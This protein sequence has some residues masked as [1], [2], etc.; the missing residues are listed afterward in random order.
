MD[1][2]VC[3]DT[4]G[5]YEKVLTGCGHPAYESTISEGKTYDPVDLGNIARNVGKTSRA[6][7]GACHFFGGGAAGVKHGDLDTSLLAPSKDLDVHM[8]MQGLNY[9]CTSCHVTFSHYIT[10]RHY[11]EPA[12]KNR[13]MALPKDDGN[14]LSCESCHGPSPHRSDDKLNHHTDIVAC[15]SCHIPAFARV[16]PT[17][18]SWD[19]SVAGRFDEKGRPFKKK[20]PPDIG[21]NY[22]TRK[23]ELV[24]AKNVTPTYRWYN[25]SFHFMR[26]GERIGDE[27]PV[28]LSGPNGGPGE[29]DSRIHPFKIHQGV[30]PYDPVTM[31][32]GIPKIFGPKGSGAYWSDFNWKA[33][34][35]AGMMSA[36]VTFSGEVDFIKTETYW[37]INHMIPPKEK[38]VGCAS[39]HARD[40]LMAEIAG[41]YI[42]GRDRSR[43]LD[44]AG[45]TFVALSAGAVSVHGLL[46]IL[47]RGREK[48][49]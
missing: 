1:C 17:V 29:P 42:P 35:A 15:Q 49:E 23:G 24:W 33:S 20:E 5:T 27:R 16:N 44:T 8:D 9:S 40:G 4:T 26:M 25:G 43:T 2:L 18:M 14:R 31:T 32:I 11:S 3:H 34:L 48:G 21:P 37:S 47:S 36:G 41:V 30:Q 7:C 19:W 22:L 45:W 6:T 28:V 38:A 46:R 10:G 12:P 13:R 39:C